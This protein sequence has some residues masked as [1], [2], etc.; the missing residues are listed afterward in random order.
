MTHYQPTRWRWYG[1]PLHE[2]LLFLSWLYSEANYLC[3]HMGLSITDHFLSLHFVVASRLTWGGMSSTITATAMQQ[4]KLKALDK[5]IKLLN[6]FL[7]CQYYFLFNSIFPFKCLLPPPCSCWIRLSLTNLLLPL[8][9][10]CDDEHEQEEDK[11]YWPR[12]HHANQLDPLKAKHQILMKK[13]RDLKASQLYGLLLPIFEIHQ[14]VTTSTVSLEISE[15]Q[16]IFTLGGWY[17]I[18][19]KRLKS[20]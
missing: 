7:L 2:K 15:W 5:L 20:T 10:W 8:K 4:L 6:I 1:F 12:I 19:T 16:K 9:L 3:H 18:F 13:E 14:N 17:K 11:N